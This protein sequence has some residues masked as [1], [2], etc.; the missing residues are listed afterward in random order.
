MMA[1]D[2]ETYLPDDVLV[3]VEHAALAVSL[4]IRL[5]LLDENKLSSKG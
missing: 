4:E 3:K 1:S 2:T 5:P